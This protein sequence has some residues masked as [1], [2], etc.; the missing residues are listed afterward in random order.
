MPKAGELDW[1]DLMKSGKVDEDPST[2]TVR[3]MFG[4]AKGD[5]SQT[6]GDQVTREQLLKDAQFILR[7]FQQNGMRQA[8]D[9]EL[10]GAL[11]VPPDELK[12]REEAWNNT[13]N[14]FFTEANKKIDD[15]TQE[16]GTCKP[17]IDWDSMTEEERRARNTHVSSDGIDD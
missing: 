9:Q 17:I 14:K 8:T 12:K 7:G 4:L 5:V 15:K 11:V 1:S 16:W 10:F 3:K 6:G 2:E 13:F